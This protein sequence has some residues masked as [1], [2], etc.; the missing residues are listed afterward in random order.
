MYSKNSLKRVHSLCLGFLRSITCIY[1]CQVVN[2]P[3]YSVLELILFTIQSQI[4]YRPSTCRGDI[5]MKPL[6]SEISK[7][8]TWKG[9][10]G[11]N[12]TWYS[13]T[14]SKNE[15]NY[16][17]HLF[18]HAIEKPLQ[19]NTLSDGSTMY[20]SNYKNFVFFCSYSWIIVF[21][22]SYSWTN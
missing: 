8:L 10:V 3:R 6:N 12:V 16:I 7:H 15:E 19:R 14:Q 18:I 21:F 22:C 13:T 4:Q 5:L 20:N 2:F 9:D 17:Y 1:F 11:Q